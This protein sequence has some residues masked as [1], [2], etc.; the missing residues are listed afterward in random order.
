MGLYA[1]SFLRFITGMGGIGCFMVSFV[2]AVEHVGC[3]VNK[4]IVDV[5]YISYAIVV[6]NVDWY[7]Y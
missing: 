4:A 1:Y 6:H 7:S 3:K 2:L 5:F